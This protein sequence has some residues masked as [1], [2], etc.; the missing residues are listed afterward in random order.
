MKALDDIG[1]KYSRET[2]KAALAQSELDSVQIKYILNANKMQGALLETTTNQL[3]NAASAN[4]MAK[5]QKAASSSTLE[6]GDAFKGLGIKLG[7]M[8]KAHPILA[9]T[10]AVI[11]L[12]AVIGLISDRINN[13]EKYA[14]KALDKSAEKVNTVKSEIDSLNSELQTTKDRID[15]LKSKENLSLVEQEELQRLKDSND[16]LER[17]IRLKQS[18]LSDEEKDA[19][20]KAKKYFS[21][22]KESLELAPGFLEHR[23]TDY[24][25]AV[26]ERLDRLQKH[27]DGEIRLSEDTIKEYKNYVESALSDFMEEDDFLIKG[28]DDGLLERLDVLYEK[29]DIYTNGRAHIIED[30][31]SGILAK[32]DFDGISKELIALGKAGDLSVAALS[33]RFPKLIAYLD[34][35]GISAEELYQYIMALANP[36]AVQ[37]DEVKRQ[38][39]VSSGIRDGEINGASD[40]KITKKLALSGVLS[41]EGL[42]VYLKIKGEYDTSSWDV[43]DWISNIQKRLNEEFPEIRIPASK[44]LS[45][46][47]DLNTELDNLGNAMANLDSEGNFDLGSLDSIAD[48][49]LGL[50][51][52]SYDADAVNNALKS[53]GDENTSIEEQADAINSLADQYLKTS[54]ILDHLNEENKELIKFQLERMGISNAETIVDTALNQTLQSQAEIE[55]VLAQYKSIVTGETLTL[56]NVTAQELKTLFAE[57][58]ITN[59]TANQMVALA[60]KK[61][62]VNGN[63]LNASADINNLIGLCKMLG[64]TTTALDTYNKVK[65]G[66]NGMPSDVVESYRKQAEQELQNAIKTGENTIAKSIPKVEYNGGSAIADLLKDTGNAAAQAKENYQELFDF[67]ERR[68]NVLNDALELLN[69]NLENVAASNAKNFLID[70]QIGIHKESANNYTDALSMYQQKAV[71]SLSKV[72]EKSKKLFNICNLA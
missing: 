51:G 30:M 6:L 62:L 32:A 8:I 5:A 60:I 10:T 21:V 27:S 50:E 19:N 71:E 68:V 58:T 49:F 13:A 28:Q 22:N 15:E 44:T 57:R 36:D 43:D 55:S 1:K 65:N 67:F 20:D 33:S 35:A 14:K 7:N 40:V 54:G 47:K 69:A 70:A 72:P 26:E 24:I 64:T 16:E 37:Y 29:Y 45:D 63:T 3:A 56:A 52:I 11:A 25:H 46:L 41:N 2:L 42:D 23:Q 9:V 34:E 17:E 39:M 66:A 61:Q 48:Y 38:L 53:L 31:I 12:G 59:A 4:K 18:L